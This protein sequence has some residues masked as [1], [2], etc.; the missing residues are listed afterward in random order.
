MSVDRVNA[1]P[2]C[3]EQGGECGDAPS[4]PQRYYQLVPGVG[5]ITGN[6]SA[7]FGGMPHELSVKVP[8]GRKTKSGPDVQSSLE[9]QVA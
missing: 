2:M 6:G 5:Y 1:C 7:R 3:R 9:K 4:S 8:G